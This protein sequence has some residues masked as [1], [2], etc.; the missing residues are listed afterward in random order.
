MEHPFFDE[1]ELSDEQIVEK[2]NK[3]HLQ[4]NHAESY[5]Q[6][7]MAESIRLLILTLQNEQEERFYMAQE[8]KLKKEKIDTTSPITLGDLTETEEK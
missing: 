1:K 4:L 6:N 3:L 7:Q 5:G 8:E 2:I